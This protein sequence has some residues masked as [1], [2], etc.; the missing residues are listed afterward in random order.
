M[1]SKMIE[2]RLLDDKSAAAALI[3]SE[4]ASNNGMFVYE[5][6]EGSKTLGLCIFSI[7][8]EK[9]RLYRVS[10]CSGGLLALEDGLMRSALSLMYKRGARDVV[11]CGKLDKALLFNTGFRQSGEQWILS[12]SESF[13][14]GCASVK[15]NNSGNIWAGFI[16]K[17]GS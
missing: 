8:G 9:G 10:M 7:T 16:D 15:K 12:L 5:A 14:A 2:I 1:V 11:C 6:V 17:S 4:L 3:S 13:F